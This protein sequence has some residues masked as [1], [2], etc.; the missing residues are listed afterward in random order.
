MTLTSFPFP[1]PPLQLRR[2]APRC[3][4]H[5]H[6]HQPTRTQSSPG[7]PCLRHHRH[8]R[9]AGSVPCR[10]RYLRISSV[11]LDCLLELTLRPSKYRPF[12]FDTQAWAARASLNLMVM[13]PSSSFCSGI[14]DAPS[15][16]AEDTYVVE[17]QTCDLS[18][19]LR[20]FPDIL[21]QIQ[22]QLR[23]LLQVLQVEHASQHDN[24]L[25]PVLQR[26]RGIETRRSFLIGLVV[27]FPGHFAVSS[28]KRTA[29][30]GLTLPICVFSWSSASY[31]RP[32]TSS[33]P[34]PALPRHRAW[35]SS[36]PERACSHSQR[37]SP[38]RYRPTE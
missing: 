9:N 38:A 17:N 11:S 24:A 22:Q 13:T 15:S 34:P 7:A 28:A 4:P 25:E 26:W 6:P 37:P 23:L 20:L 30:C 19:R 1:L 14:R 16:R 35:H 18:E 33:S 32:C 8:R 21:L 36:P 3:L 31:P 2:L 10:C 27:R 12:I 5:P 29:R